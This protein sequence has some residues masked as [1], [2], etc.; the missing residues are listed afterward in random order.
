MV[1]V[2]V[3]G[4][5]GVDDVGRRRVS[6]PLTGPRHVVPLYGISSVLLSTMCAV[7]LIENAQDG[8]PGT[9]PVPDT[10]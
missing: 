1:E 6:W 8:N 9:V 7:P 5:E 10:V 4:V 2:G 3:S